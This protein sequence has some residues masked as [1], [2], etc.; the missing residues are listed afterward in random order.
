MTSRPDPSKII[1]ENARIPN[2]RPPISRPVPPISRTSQNSGSSVKRSG[3]RQSPAGE[4]QDPSQPTKRADRASRV[5]RLPQDV[6]DALLDAWYYRAGNGDPRLT[7]GQVA[8]AYIQ[9]G[10]RQDLQRLGLPAFP[11]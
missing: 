10:L 6:A 11:R 9:E 5:V 4:Q 7:I 1:I 3:Q 2:R 8:A